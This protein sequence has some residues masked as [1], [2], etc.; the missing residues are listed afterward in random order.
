LSLWS[1]NLGNCLVHPECYILCKEKLTMEEKDA[2]MSNV[3]LCRNAVQFVSYEHFLTFLS[4]GMHGSSPNVNWA[5]WIMCPPSHFLIHSPILSEN[6]TDSLE[7]HKKLSMSQKKRLKCSKLTM[8][9]DLFSAHTASNGML[10]FSPT[11]NT[12]G[13]NRVWTCDHFCHSQSSPATNNWG[14]KENSFG[15]VVRVS[16][17]TKICFQDSGAC[18][19]NMNLERD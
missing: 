17:N 15:R 9:M 3:I 11:I 12:A 16:D 6:I 7:M 10:T 14:S 4:P 18:V 5:M 13:P 2:H 1:I 8:K 19:I